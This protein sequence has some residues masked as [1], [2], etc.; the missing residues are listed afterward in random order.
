MRKLAENEQTPQEFAKEHWKE[1]VAVSGTL[2]G[3]VI[4]LLIRY[5]KKKRIEAGNPDNDLHLQALAGEAESG[6]DETSVLLETGGAAVRHIKGA[7]QLTEQLA[8]GLPET[9]PDDLDPKLRK[10]YKSKSLKGTMR[11][12]GLIK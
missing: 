7:I 12:L 10:R 11:T 8:E 1:I 4:L 6:Y 9:L 2:A 3:A 5:H